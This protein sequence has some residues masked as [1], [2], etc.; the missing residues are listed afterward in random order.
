MPNTTSLV[1]WW[2]YAKIKRVWIRGSAG[3]SPVSRSRY[4]RRKILLRVHAPD[5]LG[6]GDET[7][8][9]NF[10]VVTPKVRDV[11]WSPWMYV[12]ANGVI[13]LQGNFKKHNI[14]IR[15]QSESSLKLIKAMFNVMLPPE[16]R[17]RYRHVRYSVELYLTHERAQGSK[18]VA[19][20]NGINQIAL[21]SKDTLMYFWLSHP[22]LHRLPRE[23][24]FARFQDYF[25]LNQS[26]YINRDV[27]YQL[28]GG[29]L[30]ARTN[31]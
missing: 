19:S 24:I 30:H 6:L 26:R 1:K 23:E 20:L 27:V 31:P 12:H 17:V 29:I 13:V 2:D 5:K 9:E 14:I 28:L 18:R 25:K 15:E 10:F 22:E 21:V 3:L 11:A 7:T 8:R 4:G 16:L